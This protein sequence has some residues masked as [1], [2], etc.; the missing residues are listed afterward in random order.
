MSKVLVISGYHDYE[1]DELYKKVF[2][3]TLKSK[4][5]YCDK[6]N[7]DFL[8][9]RK[10]PCDSKD[11]GKMRLIYCL[12]LAQRWETVVWVDADS[13][14]TNNSIS[15]EEMGLGDSCFY[16]SPDYGQ[17]ALSGGYVNT[18]NFIVKNTSQL[19][20]FS[21]AFIKAVNQFDNEQTIINHL[22]RS[23][24]GSNH[25]QILEN[26]YLGSQ[27]RCVNDVRSILYGVPVDNPR[28]WINS[29]LMAHLAGLPNDARVNIL[30]NHFSSY[31]GA[32][33]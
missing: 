23:R 13:I 14:I 22:L 15:I 19:Q 2:N 28:P 1:S 29:D 6:H 10:F 18:G 32:A 7:Y 16:A 21:A 17:W 3:M 9:I 30:N 4:I 11:I 12:D 33:I 20:E 25:I 26:K 5:D 8:T 24:G 31:L 27:P